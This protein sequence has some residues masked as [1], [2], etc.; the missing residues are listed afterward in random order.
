MNRIAEILMEEFS[1][2]GCGSCDRI[3]NLTARPEC[4]KCGLH[5]GEDVEWKLKLK[6]AEFISNRIINSIT[7]ALTSEVS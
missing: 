5:K 7:T 4:A 6:D 1:Y 2:I 3:T